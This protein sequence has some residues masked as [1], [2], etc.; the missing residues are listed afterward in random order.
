MGYR[1]GSF[2]SAGVAW[3][4]HK[5]SWLE[6][7]DILNNLKIRA[8][9]GET[10][11]NSVGLNQYQSLFGYSASYDDNGAIYPSSFG[12][13]LLSWE[14]QTLYDVGLD[15]GFLNNRIT[16]SVG[17]YNRKT[18][19][20]LQSVPLSTTTGHSSQTQ[21]VGEVENKGI[22]IELN[23]DVVKWGDFTWNIYGNYATNENEVLKLAQKADGTD[24]NLDGGY[25][26]TRVGEPMGVWYL[27]G[28]AGV[29]L[30]LIHI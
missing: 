11:S 9:I 8:S 10:G 22:E 1:F 27:R 7:N 21:N 25:N 26:R 23:A 24:I 30:S 15:F 5:E 3:N 17:Y 13:L 28:W 4:M 6:G 19:D 20:L 12:N 18:N 14:K 29:N 16:G 2:W